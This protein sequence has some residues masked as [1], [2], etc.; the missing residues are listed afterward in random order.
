MEA[1]LLA[2]LI[3]CCAAPA[4]VVRADLP[5][6]VGGSAP[7][8]A[9]AAAA[10]LTPLAEP[11]KAT[12]VVMSD[13]SW[14]AAFLRELSAGVPRVLSPGW[15]ALARRF[16]P[17]LENVLMAQRCVTLVTAEG[18]EDLLTTVRTFGAPR[19]TRVVFWS[20]V[21]SPRDGVLQVVSR[22]GL[23]L[24]G[25]QYV[26]ALT[27]PDG[28]TVLYS[29]NCFTRWTCNNAVMTI[30]EVDEWS[31]GLRRWRRG[32]APFREFCSGWRP[33][34]GQGQSLNVSLVSARGLSPRS[35][36]LDLANSLAR[37]AGQDRRLQRVGLGPH[38]IYREAIDYA[39]LASRLHECSVDAVVADTP[40]D[41]L[42]VPTEAIEVYDLEMTHV[43]A[44]VPA[45]F[46][47]SVSVLDAVTVEFSAEVWWATGLAMLCAAVVLA[48][49][50]GQDVSGAALQ[51][52]AP[53]VG[54]APPPPAPPRPPLAPWLLACVVL[55][56]AYQGLLL[57]KLSTAVPRRELDSLSDV[58]DSGLPVHVDH[59]LSWRLTGKNVLPE[60]LTAGGKFVALTEV[61]TIIDTIAT[62]RNCAF[63]L[64][65]SRRA[66]DY[67]QRYLVPPKKVHLVHLAYSDRNVIGM[68]TKGSPLARALTSLLA[69][70]DAAGLLTHWRSAEFERERQD[71][72][73][74]LVALQGPRP[75]TLYHLGPPFVVLG[76]GHVVGLAV[77]ALE[78]VWGWMAGPRA[79]CRRSASAR[80]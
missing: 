62:A 66:Q 18:L 46:G 68:A 1:L 25:R 56:A 80:A 30:R 49:A 5:V 36:L 13:S 22:T 52:L 60:N 41:V 31:P 71:R 78:A 42:R 40:L 70:V 33:R 61:E 76:V 54:Q 32:A 48:C 20:S 63:V 8:E 74:R 23:W 24:G 12:L 11:Q 6:V 4:R 29:L 51:V 67:V 2:V 28:S 27:A 47:A 53:M 72:A 38:T 69:R 44:I 35:S 50:R 57:G 16:D 19:V 3:L 34:H 15:V 77:F 75:L 43:V 64:L 55:T 7:P 9:E 73:K 21:S 59:I 39:E 10:L 14:A 65:L 37:L 26:L 45:G 17:L 79:S 58:V